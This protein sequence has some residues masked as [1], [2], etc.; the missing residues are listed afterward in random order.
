VKDLEQR[1]WLKDLVGGRTA[2]VWGSPP[3]VEGEP[4]LCDLLRPYLDR[5]VPVLTQSLDQET[6]ERGTRV[7]VLAPGSP[8]WLSACLRRAA[9]ELRLQLREVG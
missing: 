1:Y 7:A 5:P 8:D 4:G 3:R 9:Q 2:E 6:G